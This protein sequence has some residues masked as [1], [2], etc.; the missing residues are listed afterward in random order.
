MRRQEGVRGRAVGVA[1]VDRLDARGRVDVKFFCP[2]RRLWWN[3]PPL[4]TSN[5][6]RDALL[7]CQVAAHGSDIFV[8]NPKYAH[9]NLMGCTSFNRSATWQLD[10][11]SPYPKWQCVTS[12]ETN[13]T[14]EVSE[15]GNS[16][17]RVQTLEGARKMKLSVK[18]TFS[19]SNN[20]GF[21]ILTDSMDNIINS[22]FEVQSCPLSSI[23]Q[24][25]SGF[26]LGI[27]WDPDS[28][29]SGRVAVVRKD[30]EKDQ[31]GILKESWKE[32]SLLPSRTKE[33]IEMEGCISAS[34]FDITEVGPFLCTIPV[35]Q[36]RHIP[37][38]SDTNKYRNEG[39]A[40]K[41]CDA[42][43]LFSL[44]DDSYIANSEKLWE[45]TWLR[46]SS[47]GSTVTGS[48]VIDI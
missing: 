46:I 20:Y 14:P 38:L 3:A 22:K 44:T 36:I 21:D 23:D 31:M 11:S 39:F 33:E 25:E 35:E 5:S 42:R 7:S 18:N 37:S 40:L 15:R 45:A 16:L 9:G 34:S 41:F 27:S 17:T 19:G 2:V 8:F 4:L 26:E 10:S 12:M 32:V 29:L 13:G 28:A 6:S 1:I 47:L 30:T 48:V 43:T 24:S